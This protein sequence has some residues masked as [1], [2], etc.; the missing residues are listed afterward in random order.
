MNYFDDSFYFMPRQI[1][2]PM[3][4]G[5]DTAS[6]NKKQGQMMP[7][8]QMMA[9]QQMLPQTMPSPSAAALPSLP[10][11]VPGGP[12]VG[13]VPSMGAPGMGMPSAPGVSVP[14][15]PGGP[16]L[17]TADPQFVAGYLKT[18]I[19]R[20]VR[21]E[22]LIGTTGPLVDRIGTL[23]GVGVSYILLRPIE[24]DDILMCDL[25]SIKFVTVL[26]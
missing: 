1:P 10:T 20:Q 25:Y 19:G 24:S 6:M 4:N 13:P 22:F 23:M 16:I 7:Q 26:L 9:P 11:G 12:L 8:M 3:G 5:N 17:T 21:V 18:Q 14:A 2:Q 15:T